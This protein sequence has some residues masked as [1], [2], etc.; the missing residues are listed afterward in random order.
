MFFVFL[1]CFFFTFFHFFSLNFIA[2]T[3]R[4]HGVLFF[5]FV[6][7]VIFK[8]LETIDSITPIVAAFTRVLNETTSR[9]E[10]IG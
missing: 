9:R 7:P 2:A 3:Q 8:R 10:Q 4:S 5:R 6:T 1:L